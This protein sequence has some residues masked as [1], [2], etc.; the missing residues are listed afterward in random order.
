MFSKEW[1]KVVKS[2]KKG[3]LNWVYRQGLLFEK[4]KKSCKFEEMYKKSGWS[5]T[6]KSVRKVSKTLSG[7]EFK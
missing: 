1:K 2:K 4:F 5:K 7:N 3:I 6:R